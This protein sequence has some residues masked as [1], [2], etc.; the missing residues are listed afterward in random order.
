MGT[1]IAFRPSPLS[2]FV[3]K[4]ILDP[5]SVSRNKVVKSTLGAEGLKKLWACGSMEERAACVAADPELAARYTNLRRTGGDSHL[6][7]TLQSL[8]FTWWRGESAE[9][10]T[11]AYPVMRVA[12]EG[13]KAIV[14]TISAPERGGRPIAY[15]LRRSQEWLLVSERYAGRAAQ[16][17]PRSPV[18]RY[19]AANADA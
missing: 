4:W 18:F 10:K 11:S 1:V 12:M 17:F 5:L 15:V 6:V 9:P 13:R 8:T 16:L 14:H 3:G 19:Y 7:V 2:P